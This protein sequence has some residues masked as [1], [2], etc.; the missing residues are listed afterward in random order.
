MA[1]SSQSP[2][3]PPES[4]GP[5]PV[6]IAC[7][8]MAVHDDMLGGMGAQTLL[9]KVARMVGRP[10]LDVRFWQAEMVDCASLRRQVMGDVAEAELL[11][12]V[13][14]AS[15]ELTPRIKGWLN[16]WQPVLSANRTGVALLVS[17]DCW[18]QTAA[19]DLGRRF[20]D[21]ARL[22]QVDCLIGTLPD[23]WTKSC[24]EA[25]NPG[26]VRNVC[27]SR[28]PLTGEREAF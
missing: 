27:A 22:N 18:Q 5:E 2:I 11:M 13:M 21:F 9:D 15:V 28:R 20:R 10:S 17:G 7:R 19:R 3:T 4:S 25:R 26:R 1:C 14:S 8:V 24:S 12:F 23:G 6:G 16:C